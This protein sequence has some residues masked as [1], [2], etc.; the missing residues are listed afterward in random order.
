MINNQF[1]IGSADL[2]VLNSVSCH[3]SKKQTISFAMRKSLDDFYQCINHLQVIDQRPILLYSD[4]N[5]PKL[6]IKLGILYFKSLQIPIV[7]FERLP[8]FV[9]VNIVYGMGAGQGDNFN[10]INNQI[11]PKEDLKLWLLNLYITST[12]NNKYIKVI[13]NEDPIN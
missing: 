9:S 3:Y 7:F 12:M 5:Q 11:I 10:Y 4:P 8:D 1:T 13:L 2:E 6:E